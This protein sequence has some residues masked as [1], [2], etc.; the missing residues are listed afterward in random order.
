MGKLKR[1]KVDLILILLILASGCTSRRMEDD[2]YKDVLGVNITPKEQIFLYNEE[3]A[4]NDGFSL[5][6]V[7]FNLNGEIHF[8]TGFSKIDKYRKNM[9]ISKWQKTPKLLVEDFDLIFKYNIDRPD[10]RQKINDAYK[11][12]KSNDNFYS[13]FYKKESD[14]VYSVDLY[15]LDVER[16]LLYNFDVE[17]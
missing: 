13:Y 11:V 7:R 14:H 15:I 3:S 12:L 2:F 10:V 8:A 4:N 16:K 9:Q 17:I 6:I 1:I 5:E